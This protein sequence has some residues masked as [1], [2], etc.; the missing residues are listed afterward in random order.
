MTSTSWPGRFVK[1]ATQSTRSAA[2][3]QPYTAAN[4]ST[5]RRLRTSSSS[6]WEGAVR[7]AGDRWQAKLAVASPARAHPRSV[8][9]CRPAA[10][11]DQA[12]L[13]GA[14]P[15]ERVED[16]DDRCAFTEASTVRC[17]RSALRPASASAAATS[18]CRPMP[19]KTGEVS[20]T[21]ALTEILDASR[22]V[23]GS[24]VFAGEEGQADHIVPCDQGPEKL[25]ET[26]QARAMTDAGQ[27][28]AGRGAPPEFLVGQFV[29]WRSS[30]A[31]T[32]QRPA[33]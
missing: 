32:A 2:T 27:I 12:G 23:V 29:G 18:T 6:F 30:P 21:C 5:G 13:R 31:R 8:R 1:R 15:F 33:R 7:R 26:C 17:T 14:H 20:T 16:K 4:D 10:G 25:G 9:P 28:L 22:N 11:C 24:A 19:G 3:S